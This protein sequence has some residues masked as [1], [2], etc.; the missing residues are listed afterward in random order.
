MET[1]KEL[2]KD[3]NGLLEKHND[4]VRGYKEAAEKAKSPG[5]KTF[6]QRNAGTRQSFAAD[7]SKRR[8]AGW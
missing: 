8:I 3:L 4:A 2:V 1:N 6:L 5:L 7:L